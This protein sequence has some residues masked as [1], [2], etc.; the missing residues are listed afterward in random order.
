MLLAKPQ[1][2]MNLSGRSVR[3]LLEKR[4]LSAAGDDPGLR[5]PGSALDVDADPAPRDL[6]AGTTGWSR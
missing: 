5:R 3:T 6:P 4:S 2:Y 1:T